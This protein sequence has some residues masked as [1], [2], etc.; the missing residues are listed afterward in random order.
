MAAKKNDTDGAVSAGTDVGQAEVQAVADTA[1][2]QGFLGHTTDPTPTENYTL[3]G[4][5]AGKPTPE[6]DSDAA[7]EA[8]KHQSALHNSHF[9]GPTVAQQQ[10]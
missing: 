5:T 1:T 4:V 8:W 10:K 9:S 6:T 3:A 2:E 7:V